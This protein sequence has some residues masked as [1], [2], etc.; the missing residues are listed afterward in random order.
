[1]L[2]E[3]PQYK[4]PREG[5]TVGQGRYLLRAMVGFGSSG[6]VYEAQDRDE[7]ATVAVK[8]MTTLAGLDCFARSRFHH[9]ALV[10]QKLRHPSVVRILDHGG[11]AA[12]VPFIVMDLLRGETLAT[13]LSNR[14]ALNLPEGIKLF[15]S[16]L[17]ALAYCHSKGIVHRDLTLRNTVLARCSKGMRLTLVDFGLASDVRECE[18]IVPDTAYTIGTP[19]FMAPEQ[20]RG[21][22]PEPTTDVY[23]FAVALVIGLTGYAPFPRED[24]LGSYVAK[25]KGAIRAKCL[26]AIPLSLQGFVR[27]CLSPSPKERPRDGGAARLQFEGSRAEYGLGSSGMRPSIGNDATGA[28]EEPTLRSVVC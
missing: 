27:G 16:L 17:S 14:G 13:R 19:T 20:L 6:V 7:S 25:R 22:P 28:G 26:A 9:E 8:V 18:P 1:M 10:L 15:S 24:N 12:G 11:E 4:L 3:L 2:N 5:D 23:A 21:D